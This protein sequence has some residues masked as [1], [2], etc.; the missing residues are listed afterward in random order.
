MD[1]NRPFYTQLVSSSSSSMA[2]TVVGKGFVY[3]TPRSNAITKLSLYNVVSYSIYEPLDDS[4]PTK[5]VEV[6]R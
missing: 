4:L 1:L 5:L 6:Q 2:L 3:I